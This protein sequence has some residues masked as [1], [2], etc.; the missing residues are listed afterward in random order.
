MKLNVILFALVCLGL[1]ALALAHD[2]QDL[3]GKRADDK[4]KDWDWNDWK[5]DDKDDHDCND[6]GDEKEEG[7]C[8]WKCVKVCPTVIPV[9]V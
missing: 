1:L 3:G 4:Q 5:G 7:K 2:G 9:T 8:F 6:D